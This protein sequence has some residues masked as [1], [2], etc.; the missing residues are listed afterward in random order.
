MHQFIENKEVEETES[1]AI[2]K[3]LVSKSVVSN[4]LTSSFDYETSQLTSEVYNNVTESDQTTVPIMQTVTSHGELLH[5]ILEC[6]H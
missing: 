3:S 5:S 1:S 2:S 6:Y 4:C